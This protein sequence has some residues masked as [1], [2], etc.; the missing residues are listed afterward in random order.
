MRLF[1][2]LS[3]G[4]FQRQPAV[5]HKEIF[6]LRAHRF[7]VLQS[8]TL[9]DVTL[10]RR[11]GPRSGGAGRT[12]AR[13]SFHHLAHGRGDGRAGARGAAAGLAARSRT[14]PCAPSCA[15][16]KKR[17]TSRIRSR[18]APFSTVPPSR[19]SAWPAAPSSASWTGSARA[20][21]KRCWWAWSIQKCSIGANCNAGRAH[22]RGTEKRRRG[23]AS[24]RIN[25]CSR[26]R[27][28]NRSPEEG[29]EIMMPF[30]A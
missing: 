25:P 28:W 1:R 13:H 14:R 24:P 21:S 7:Y 2:I 17:A 23:R 29:G 22:R 20:R 19:G 26:P 15:A 5:R 9:W 4:A 16:S 18:T 30:A 3:A 11:N 12:G 10:N 8:V 27:Q 6:Q